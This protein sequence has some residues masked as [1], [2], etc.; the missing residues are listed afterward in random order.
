MVQSCVISA[1]AE[2]R[3]LVVLVRGRAAVVSLVP[4]Q[5]T[6]VSMWVTCIQWGSGTQLAV[7]EFPAGHPE[8]EAEEHELLMGATCCPAPVCPPAAVWAVTPTREAPFI[9]SFTLL[10]NSESIGELYY[11]RVVHSVMNTEKWSLSSHRLWSSHRCTRINLDKC[12]DKNESSVYF[13][14]KNESSRARWGSQVRLQRRWHW[15]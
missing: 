15:S 9:Y 4:S 11:L 5:W 10:H 12:F 3:F 8:R 1:G 2:G 13:H 14:F 6:G 7:L